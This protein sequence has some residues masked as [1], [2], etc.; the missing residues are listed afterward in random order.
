MIGCFALLVAAVAFEQPHVVPTPAK[1]DWQLDQC[2]EL[3]PDLPVLLALEDQSQDE[4]SV[5]WVREHA[6]AAFGVDLKV[7]ACMSPFSNRLRRGDSYGLYVSTNSVL[8]HA[9]GLEGVRYAFQT[10]R[11]IAMPKRGTLKVDGW[12]APGCTI[13]DE[14]KSKFRGIHLCWFPETKVSTL[15]RCIRLAGYYK[16]N[17]VVLETWGTFRSEKYPWWGWKDGAMT[18]A[19]IRRLKAVADDLG[20]TLVPQF[21]VFGHASMSRSQSGKHAVLDLNREYQPLFEPH[22]G[23]NWCLSNPEAQKVVD[24]LV[25]E[26]HEAFGNPPY[27]HIGCDEA[28]PPSCPTCRAADYVELV[29]S[30]ITRVASILEKRGARAMMWHD[31]LLKQGAW[32]RFYAH[33]KN[34]EEKLL[35]ILPKSIVICDWFYNEGVSP[36]GY[37]TFAHFRKAGYDVLCSPWESVPGTAAQAKAAHEAGALGLLGTTWHHVYKRT[38]ANQFVPCAAGGWGT[39]ADSHG[40]VDHWRQ[41]GWDM[42]IDGYDDCGFVTEQVPLKTNIE[43]KPGG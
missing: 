32:G 25:V 2:V 26:M 29:A 15:E 36:E 10:L 9:V 30:N 31:M 1:A 4:C 34:G 33:A 3:K 35:G 39:A 14:P 8:F 18:K 27:F 38:I 16:M 22:H 5:R 41:M 42:G 20:V 12:I 40:F 19:E 11:Q 6:H 43:I 28:H 7:R 24:G 37:P 17:T 23:W 21:N 13:T